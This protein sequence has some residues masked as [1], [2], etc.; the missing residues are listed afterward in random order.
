MGLLSI[1]EVTMAQKFPRKNEFKV[2]EEKASW[3]ALPKEI[4]H[5]V[6]MESVTTRYGSSI[7]ATLISDGCKKYK[8]FMPGSIKKVIGDRKVPFYILNNGQKPLSNDDT[9]FYYEVCFQN[10][11]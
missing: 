6:S 9:K 2:V 4:F 5:V 3:K 7:I 8:I 11:H 10:V 1:S